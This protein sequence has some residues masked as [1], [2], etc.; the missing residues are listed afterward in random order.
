MLGEGGGFAGVQTAPTPASDHS[1]PPKTLLPCP[2]VFPPSASCPHSCR[3]RACCCTLKTAEGGRNLSLDASLK[4]RAGRWRCPL[5]ARLNSAPRCIQTPPLNLCGSRETYSSQTS[6]HDRADIK[7]NS[8]H[9]PPVRPLFKGGQTPGKNHTSPPLPI[10]SF[11]FFLHP[12]DA[13]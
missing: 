2:R 13:I 8:V 5:H 10:S 6:V 12:F 1:G 4:R 11:H 7:Q 9:A 3:C